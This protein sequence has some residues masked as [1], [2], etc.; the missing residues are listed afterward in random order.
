MQKQVTCDLCRSEEAIY[1]RRE[2]GE[3]FCLKCLEKSLIKRVSKCINKYNML[4]P[5]DSILYFTSSLNLPVSIQLLKILLLIEKNFPTRITIVLP[6]ELTSIVEKYKSIKDFEVIEMTKT[7]NSD[8]DYLELF[9]KELKT[10]FT[11]ARPEDKIILPLT[12]DDIV[13]LYITIILKPRLELVKY[14]RPKFTINGSTYITPFRLIPSREIHMLYY[15]RASQ[16]YIEIMKRIIPIRKGPLCDIVDQ[17]INSIVRLHFEIG[18]LIV[19]RIDEL[20]NV[21]NL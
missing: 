12:L 6:Y 7:N 15:M 5:Q 14:L 16:E 18:Y 1:Y 20:Y 21:M 10:A 17:I 8:Y 3:R 11:L 4:T 13:K 19:D 9:L 2:S